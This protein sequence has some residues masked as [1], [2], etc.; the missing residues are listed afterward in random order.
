MV[1]GNAVEFFTGCGYV[2]PFSIDLSDFCRSFRVESDAIIQIVIDHEV[3][4][5]NEMHNVM[6]RYKFSEILAK[7]LYKIIFWTQNR[8]KCKFCR[9]IRRDLG[10]IVAAHRFLQREKLFNFDKVEH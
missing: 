6:E 10:F 1:T 4:L 2:I 7:I 3:L 5:I 9:I 8:M